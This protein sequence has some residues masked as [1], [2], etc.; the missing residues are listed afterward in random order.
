M[1][2]STGGKCRRSQSPLACLPEHQSTSLKAE[3][4]F[5][6]SVP[7]QLDSLFI[8]SVPSDWLM[9]MSDWSVL[10]YRSLNMI[11]NTPAFRGYSKFPW[12]MFRQQRAKGEGFLRKKYAKTL[13]GVQ[14]RKKETTLRLICEFYLEICLGGSQKAYILP[15]LLFRVYWPSWNFGEEFQI[16]THAKCHVSTLL[17]DDKMLRRITKEVVNFLLWRN[18][19]VGFPLMWNVKGRGL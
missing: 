12:E 13:Y 19:E 8:A 17:T 5:S 10:P 14:W 18:L 2:V 6:W 3:L 15:F 11:N 7:E 16:S 4:M 9:P 1:Y